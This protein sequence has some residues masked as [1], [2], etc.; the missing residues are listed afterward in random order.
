MSFTYRHVTDPEET[1]FTFF[2]NAWRI[3]V[4]T[5]EKVMENCDL[6]GYFGYLKYDKNKTNN[7]L[8]ILINKN[9]FSLYNA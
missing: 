2:Q 9:V 7:L 6:N 1:D 8:S 4:A 3:F 5:H